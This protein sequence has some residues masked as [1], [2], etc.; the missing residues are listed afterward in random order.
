M[1][2]L[3][4]ANRIINAEFGGIAGRRNDL[5]VIEADDGSFGFV[6]AERAKQGK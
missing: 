6:R 2:L 5:K 4:F 3:E 1:K